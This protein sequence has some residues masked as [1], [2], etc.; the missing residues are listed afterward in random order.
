M[1]HQQQILG[2]ASR[3]GADP[4]EVELAVALMRTGRIDLIVQ[5]TAQKINNSRRSGESRAIKTTMLSEPERG[6]QV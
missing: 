2:L 3:M 4:R 6:G 1:T 5:V